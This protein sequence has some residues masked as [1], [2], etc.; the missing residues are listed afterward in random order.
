VNSTGGGNV[1]S[2]SGS[3]N[4]NETNTVFNPLIPSTGGS[5][6]NET[7]PQEQTGGGAGNNAITIDTTFTTA[8]YVEFE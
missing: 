6:E 5:V 7:T 4:G 1:N 8:S 2:T 3:D